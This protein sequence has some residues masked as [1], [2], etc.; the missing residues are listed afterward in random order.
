MPPRHGGAG[1]AAERGGDGAEDVEGEA[2]RGDDG[3]VGGAGGDEGP[4]MQ[5]MTSWPTVTK[6]RMPQVLP[7]WRSQKC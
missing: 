6:P 1:G 2:A 5:P 7:P 4:K 3:R